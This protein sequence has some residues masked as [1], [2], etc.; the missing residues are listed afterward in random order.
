MKVARWVLRGRWRSNALLLPDNAGTVACAPSGL[1]WQTIKWVKLRRQVRKLQARIVKATQDGKYGKVKA[2]QWLLTHSFSGKALAVKRVTENDGKKTPGVDRIIWNTSTAKTKAIVSLQKRGYKP[3]PLLR[4]LIPKKKDKT[5][6]IGILAMKDRGMQA[7]YLLA[8]E[9]VAETTADRNSYGFRPERSTADAGAKCFMCL[10]GKNR[11]EW[12]LEADI[13]GCFDNISHDWMTANIPT[14]KTVLQKW[15]KAGF[16]YQHK[17]FPT[18]AGT[19]QGGVISPALANMTLDGLEKALAEAFPRAAQQGLKMNMVRYADDFIITG[20]SKEWLQDEVMPVLVNFLA[21]RGL[22]LSPE[23][24]KITHITEGFDFLG[25]NMRKYNGK[26][27]IKPSKANIKAHLKKMREIIKGN[28][29]MKQE[30]LIRLLNPVLRGWANYHCHIVAKKTFGYVDAQVWS[31]LWR[32]ATRRHPNK[33]ARW[34]KAKYFK[35]RGSRN[36]VFAAE[37][38]KQGRKE[39]RLLLESD[40]PLRR[41]IKIKADANPFDQKWEKY[42]VARRVNKR[43]NSSKGQN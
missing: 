33:G 30:S 37:D 19:P 16:V 15:L 40:T 35:T 18:E 17:L 12:V 36:W 8:L 43:Q 24:T 42:F 14:D 11:A 1:R 34:V 23:K 10:A 38:E 25:W 3:L 20:N 21:V 6:P 7:L 5:R 26:L 41:H 2:L 32:W 4:V 39:I 22:T 13:T 31:M 29:A 9:P 28:K 27:L